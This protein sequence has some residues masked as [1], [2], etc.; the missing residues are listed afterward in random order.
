MHLALCLHTTSTAAGFDSRLSSKLAGLSYVTGISLRRPSGT[1]ARF[2]VPMQQTQFALPALP[3][4]WSSA[5]PGSHFACNI[6]D[7]CKRSCGNVIMCHDQE[8]SWKLL[9]AIWQALAAPSSLARARPVTV[10]TAMSTYRVQSQ[11]WRFPA[12]TRSCRG[13]AAGD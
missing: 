9:Q 6:K 3:P 8:S 1:A 5:S 4:A 12:H 13:D 2:L 11:L 10:T 7:H